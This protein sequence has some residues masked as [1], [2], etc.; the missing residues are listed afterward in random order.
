MEIGKVTVTF[1][2]SFFQPAQGEFG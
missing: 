1:Q 2:K